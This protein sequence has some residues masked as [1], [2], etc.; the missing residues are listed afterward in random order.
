MP[1]Y[2]SKE[3]YVFNPQEDYLMRVRY[4]NPTDRPQDA[5]AGLI[6]LFASEDGQLPAPTGPAPETPATHHNH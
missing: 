1:T 5:M 4:N 2:T 6:I 3:G